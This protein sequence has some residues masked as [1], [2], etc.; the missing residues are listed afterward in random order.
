MLTKNHVDQPERCILHA[1]G[2]AC[3]L[4][5]PYGD[6]YCNGACCYGECVASSVPG[7]KLTCEVGTALPPV[8]L[9]P[10]SR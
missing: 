5:S 7:Q 3:C 6:D 8:A 9:P 1:G 4:E 10:D 2:G